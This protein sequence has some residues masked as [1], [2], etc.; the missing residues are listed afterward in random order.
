MHYGTTGL[1]RFNSKIGLWFHRICRWLF[2]TGFLKFNDKICSFYILHLPRRKDRKQKL[3]KHLSEI[4]LTNGNGTLNDHAIWWKGYDGVKKWSKKEHVGVYSFDLHWTVDPAPWFDL[5]PGALEVFKKKGQTIKCSNAESSIA[6]GHIK[7]WKD[8]LKSDKECALFVE[9]DVKFSFRFEERLNDILT[10]ELNKSEYDMLYLSTLPS[11]HGFTW[12]PHTKNTLR[13][14]NGIW[15]M[16]GYILTKRGAQKLIDNLPI[17][18][19]VDVWINHIFPQMN[20]FMSKENLIVQA[21]GGWSDNTYSFPE[22]WHDP[23]LGN[24]VEN[25]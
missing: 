1:A 23:T 10:K 25:K 7:M 5:E 14:F 12:D 22:F 19:P 20:V 17:V 2:N 16:S 3:S 18:G 9:D 13:V 6:L 15:W 24:S 4:K 11:E 8:F 21:D